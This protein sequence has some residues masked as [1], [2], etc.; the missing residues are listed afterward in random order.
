VLRLA[1]T[2]ADLGRDSAIEDMHMAEAMQYRI[3]LGQTP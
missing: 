3:F 1:Q 2:I